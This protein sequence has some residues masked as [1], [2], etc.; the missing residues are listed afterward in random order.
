MLVG[1]SAQLRKID[2]TQ[3]V[4]VAGVVL[5]IVNKLK[6][7]GVIVDCQLSFKLH[8]N[9]IAKACNY[10]I[11]ALRHIYRICC[12]KMLHTLSQEAL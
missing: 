7:L 12:L 2:V 8:V 9:A 11:W 3:T 5:P 10:H 1:T 6:S 4:K